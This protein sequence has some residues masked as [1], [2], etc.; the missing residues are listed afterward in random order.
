MEIK[1][2]SINAE[3]HQ[4]RGMRIQN[5][6]YKIPKKARKSLQSKTLKGLKEEYRETTVIPAQPKSNLSQIID[7]AKKESEERNKGPKRFKRI[8]TPSVEHKVDEIKTNAP[9]AL[10]E[11]VGKEEAQLDRQPEAAKKKPTKNKGKKKN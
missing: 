6:N 9:L 2:C 7:K 8:S 1:S 10:A 5:L 4:R 11:T 3:R